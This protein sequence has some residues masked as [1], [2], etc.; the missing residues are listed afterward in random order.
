MRALNLQGV[1][2]ALLWVGVVP[3]ASE[4]S[5]KAVFFLEP[6]TLICRRQGEDSEADGHI[7]ALILS[8]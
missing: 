3:R 2:T 8:C 6:E 5:G 7:S 1:S 4:F